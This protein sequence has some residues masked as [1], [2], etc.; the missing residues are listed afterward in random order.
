[1]G[2][3]KL[4]DFG[5]DPGVVDM[6]NPLEKL[7]IQGFQAVEMISGRKVQHIANG[8]FPGGYGVVTGMADTERIEQDSIPELA[9]PVGLPERDF[10]L[11]LVAREEYRIP[12]IL[13]DDPLLFENGLERDIGFPVELAGEFVGVEILESPY[14]VI[15]VDQDIVLP[16]SAQVV[17]D[18]SRV[19]GVQ[20]FLEVRSGENR[21]SRSEEFG[22]IHDSMIRT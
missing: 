15:Q 11:A 1:M 4:L 10:F 3:D 14:A 8:A 2:T 16:G 12:V 7:P 5:Y 20:D 18:G 21:L 9:G 22:E 6:R 19:L 17:P 13:E